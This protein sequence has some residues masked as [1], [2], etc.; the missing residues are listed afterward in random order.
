MP[1][2]RPAR[3]SLSTCRA[4]V[5]GAQVAVSLDHG[6]G[7]PA[8]EGCPASRRLPAPALRPGGELVGLPVPISINTAPTAEL[9][10]AVR[11]HPFV[12][13]PWSARWS[14]D[15]RQPPKVHL[16]GPAE[17]GVEGKHKIRPHLERQPLEHRFERL[18]RL[19]H[20]QLDDPQR[21][22][23]RRPPGERDGEIER[24]VKNS[25]RPEL[26]SNTT[27]HAAAGSYS[28]AALAVG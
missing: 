21:L 3:T 17:P 26:C 2:G 16:L 1:S 15:P 27:C 11:V 4:Q 9:K 12:S 22:N 14:A 23:N 28:T 7:A 24:E 19:R 25:S 20:V 6:Q 13:F 10:G 18:K 8:A 5:I